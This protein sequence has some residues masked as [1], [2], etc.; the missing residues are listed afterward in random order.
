ME[1]RFVATEVLSRYHVKLADEN[2]EEMFL[3]G[4]KDGFT[5]ASSGLKVVFTRRESKSVV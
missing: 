5:L 2:G 3:E 4:L 1:M